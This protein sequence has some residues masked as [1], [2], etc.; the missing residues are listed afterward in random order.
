MKNIYTIKERKKEGKVPYKRKLS[1]RIFINTS[2]SAVS[3]PE[4]L[5]LISNEHLVQ[6]QHWMIQSN[7]ERISYNSSTQGFGF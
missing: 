2:P 5:K 7:P 1:L 6:I 4:I 3:D